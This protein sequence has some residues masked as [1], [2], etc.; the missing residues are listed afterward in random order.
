LGKLAQS[1][2]LEAFLH[3]LEK[4]A[5]FQQQLDDASS[6]LQISRLIIRYMLDYTYCGF[7]EMKHFIV[8]YCSNDYHFRSFQ[9][10]VTWICHAFCKQMPSL[11]IIAGGHFSFLIISLS[12]D[13][14]FSHLVLSTTTCIRDTEDGNSTSEILL[15]EL[16]ILAT[17]LSQDPNLGCLWCTPAQGSYLGCLS[18]A[19]AQGSEPEIIGDVLLHR[20][21][22]WDMLWHAPAQ[23]P[24][25]K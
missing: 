20:I 1:L 2:M 25:L 16:C 4:L 8:Q 19:S 5:W 12:V 17:V 15:I 13:D 24:N 3:M 18:C 22:T 11:V 6:C 23:G 21:L 14:A 10:A 7:W 9:I